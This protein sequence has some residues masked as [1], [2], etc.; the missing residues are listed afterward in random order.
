MR[1]DKVKK[2]LKKYKG[3]HHSSIRMLV[4]LL[5]IILLISTASR[6]VSLYKRYT[7]LYPKGNIEQNILDNLISDNKEQMFDMLIH[8]GYYNASAEDKISTMKLEKDLINNHTKTELNDMLNSKNFSN[9]IFDTL[10][11]A[12]NKYFKSSDVEH[13]NFL[14]IG[15]E[16]KLL[17]AKSNI[18]HD[19]FK[20]LFGSETAISWDTFF[21]NVNNPKRAKKIFNDLKNT[22]RNNGHIVIMRIDGKYNGK[23]LYNSSDL[24]DIY[25]E[26]GIDGLKGFGYVTLST[27][28]EDG[29]ILGHSDSIFMQQNL[30][31]KKI[32][33]YHY[34]DIREYI[35]NNVDKLVEQNVK[36][37]YSVSMIDKEVI[38]DF[39][40]SISTV[41]FNIITIIGLMFIYK[42]LEED[43][44]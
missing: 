27:I 6:T 11:N 9:S 36:N 5:I 25:N 21:N 22:N 19:K 17:Y 37:D 35:L 42:L 31:C 23:R 41:I 24:M 39:L 30:E 8:D 28:T 12:N 43:L 44:E 1:K 3:E 32:Y 16:D 40:F 15:T 34:M 33:V 38:N 18:D 13:T 4:L 26:K 10:N 2:A 14:I 20:H 29:D 7:T